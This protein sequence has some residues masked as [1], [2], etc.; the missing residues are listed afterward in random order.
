[1]QRE[2]EVTAEIL[3]AQKSLEYFELQLA[4]ALSSASTDLLYLA[5]KSQLAGSAA[6]RGLADDL[7]EFSRFKEQYDQLR[8]ID[9]TGREII[10]INH[11]TGAEPYLVAPEKLQNKNDRYYVR[12]TLLLDQGEIYVSPLDLNVENNQLEYPLKPMIRISTPVFDRGGK[13]QGLLV[14]NY[15]AQALLHRLDVFENFLIV[16]E[17]G[18]FIK[19]MHKE[20][21][22]SIVF[23]EKKTLA[24]YF[25]RIWRELVGLKEG[26]RLNSHGLFVV[27]KIL[28]QPSSDRQSG[29]VAIS[30]TPRTSLYAT[31]D[32]LAKNLAAA[33][34][35]VALMVFVFLRWLMRTREEKFKQRRLLEKSESSLRALSTRLIH[36]QEQERKALARDLHDELGQITT[37]LKIILG[38]ARSANR[39]AALAPLLERAQQYVDTLLR[40]VRDISSRLRPAIIDDLELDESLKSLFAEFEQDAGLTVKSSF[41]IEYRVTDSQVKTAVYR[42]LQEALNNVVKH[43]GCRRAEVLVDA[44][45]GMLEVRVADRGKGLSPEGTHG[46]SGLLGM[47]ERI[48]ALHGEFSLESQPGRGTMIRVKIPLRQNEKNGSHAENPAYFS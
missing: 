8:L 27:K 41:A 15:K 35:A 7:I 40:D 45:A 39:D 44:R 42:L 37:A 12:E 25:P 21:D 13:K 1:V 28:Q 43:A 16:D 3:K 22:W 17:Q 14:L 32:I 46:G 26:R 34:V 9:I 10:R 5:K 38:Q 30:F 4:N 6:W 20:D 23:P 11:D 24:H 18:K 47:K 19:G 36:L 2:G 33:V 48:R 29:L 31:S